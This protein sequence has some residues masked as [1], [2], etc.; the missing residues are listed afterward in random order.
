MSRVLVLDAQARHALVVIRSLGRRG[1]TVTAGNETRLNAG[2]L[3]KYT[4][5]R[6]LYP[7]P[8]TDEAAFLRAIEEELSTYDYEMLLP[9]AQHTVELVV[10]NRARFEPYTTVPFPPT[11][12]VDVGLDKAKTVQAARAVGVP[13]PESVLEVPSDLDEVADRLGYPVVVKPRHGS[14]RVGVAVCYSR[15]DL[16]NAYRK[17]VER[18]GPTILQE[19]IPYGE[20]RGVYTLYD[21]DG[22]LVRVT[23]QRRLRSHPP[24]GGASTYRETVEDPELVELA[25]RLLTSLGWRDGVA[26]VE[27]RTDP[28][29]GSPVLMEVNP[30]LWGSLALSVFAGVDFPYL[31]SQLALGKP[32]ARDLNYAVGVRARD[33]FTDFQQ[34]LKREDR[35]AALAE[36]L[37]PSSH[38]CCFDVLSWDDPLPTAGHCLYYASHVRRR[39]RERL[40]TSEPAEVSAE[41]RPPRSASR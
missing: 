21:S 33:L 36:F 37:E 17:T 11:E 31:L 39:V 30:R 38:P 40:T 16:R 23:V 19:F 20:E 10:R 4:S 34:V 7:A 3:S 35:A 27:F 6:L 26:M 18:H 32:V 8:A 29:T 5:R 9:V 28:R 12:V 41:N 14:G 25:D 22:Q 1:Y 13:V 24:E 15:D 2:W